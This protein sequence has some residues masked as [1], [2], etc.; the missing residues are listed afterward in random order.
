MAR[1]IYVAGES[2]IPEVQRLVCN[3]IRDVEC[4]IGSALTRP[5][6]TLSHLTT[7]K[8]LDGEVREVAWRPSPQ[9]A[10][11]R[12]RTFSPLRGEKVHGGRMRGGRHARKAALPLSSPYTVGTFCSLIWM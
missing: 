3:P 11:P 8:D 2:C 10:M 4:T 9:R 1:V 12:I 5:S 7:G 6:A